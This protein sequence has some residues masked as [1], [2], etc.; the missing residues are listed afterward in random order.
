MLN[1]LDSPWLC[2]HQQPFDMHS[3]SSH[4]H[5]IQ[6]HAHSYF[7]H[8]KSQTYGQ[9]SQIADYDRMASIQYRANRF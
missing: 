3:T 2:R 5:T 8:Y 7:R 6:K 4:N 1:Y 9:Y